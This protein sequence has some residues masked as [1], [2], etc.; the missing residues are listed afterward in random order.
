MNTYSYDMDH[1]TKT[2]IIN[3]YISVM[4][5][6]FGSVLHDNR[7]III[8]SFS[9]GLSI[10][11]SQYPTIDENI[12]QT[13]FMTMDNMQEDI[14]ESITIRPNFRKVAQGYG[15]IAAYSFYLNNPVSY[16]SLG[17][18]HRNLLMEEYLSLINI[19]RNKIKIFFYGYY[20]SSN[21]LDIQ[22]INTLSKQ[23]LNAFMKTPGTMYPHHFFDERSIPFG[24]AQ[25]HLN[26]AFSNTILYWFN[27]WKDAGGYI[28]DSPYHNIKTEDNHKFLAIIE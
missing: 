1:N 18:D 27:I 4:P 21:I 20:N 12:R 11:Y 13:L 17:D 28:K 7:N 3:S 22:T 15:M 6:L 2:R 23:L 26:S 25:M 19:N 5:P 9:E 8:N 16:L 24:I 14:M 10:L